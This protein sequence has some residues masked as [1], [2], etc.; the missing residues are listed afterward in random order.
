[1]RG[2]S[3]LQKN[4]SAIQL[5]VILELSSARTFCFLEKGEFVL[6]FFLF[7]DLQ[8][9]ALKTVIFIYLFI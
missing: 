2:R 1:M 7:T 3:I 9:K 5:G 4:M 8:D 6:F